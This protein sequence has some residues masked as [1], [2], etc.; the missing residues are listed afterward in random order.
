MALIPFAR[1]RLPDRGSYAVARFASAQESHMTRY[2]PPSRQ[3]VAKAGHGVA[4]SAR[5]QV[6]LWTTRDGREIPLD[7]MSDE[8]ARNAVAAL[9]RWRAR[10][11]RQP[12]AEQTVRDIEDAVSRFRR[13]L[14]RR[15]KA[16]K[17]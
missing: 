2:V 11:R 15:A 17:S 7:E 9:M 10:I 3:L 6:L 14:R 13:L 16:A 1:H 8:H 4:A 5:A 12:G